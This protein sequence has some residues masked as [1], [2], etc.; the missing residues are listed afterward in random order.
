[1][2]ARR[3]ADPRW[4]S[5]QPSVTET[6]P[7]FRDSGGGTVVPRRAKLVLKAMAAVSPPSAFSPFHTGDS[8]IV[9]WVE[10]FE[11]AYLR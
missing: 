2:P 9:E 6:F 11:V 7:G 1:M 5:Q 8:F 10:D 3:V 4:S